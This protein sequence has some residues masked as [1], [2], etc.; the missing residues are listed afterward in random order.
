MDDFG[1]PIAGGI[2]AV[3]R[4]VS[5][6][7]FRPMQ[8][9]E[10]VQAKPDPIT[11][12][13]LSQNSLALTSISQQLQTVSSQ[14]ASLNFSLNGIKE[15]L[16]VSD[17][18]ERQREAARRNRERILAEQG[19]REGKE[20][21]LERKI[22][23]ALTSPLRRVAA[24]TRGILARLQDFFLIIAGGWLTATGIDLL[25]AMAEGNVDKINEYKNKFLKGLLVIGGAFTALQVGIGVTI[26]L[27]SRFVGTVARV[28]FGGI[29][30]GAFRGVRR[31]LSSV[32]GQ[33]IGGGIGGFFG[34]AAGG[35]VSGAVS[36]AAAGAG[37][38][39]G[40]KKIE[41]FVFK[42]REPRVIEK[43]F[44]DGTKTIK[45][46]D[47]KLIENVKPKGFFG[48]SVDKIKGVFGSNKVVQSG[49]KTFE[50]VAKTGLGK[51]ISAFL[52]SSTAKLLGKIVSRGGPLLGFI[53][54]IAGGEKIDNAIAGA[55][56]FAAGAAIGQAIIPIPIVGAL[57]GGIVGE[58]GLK[59]LYKG[60]KFLF[61]RLFGFN[62]KEEIRELQTEDLVSSDNDEGIEESITPVAKN[63]SEVAT[64]ISEVNEGKPTVVNIPML[65]SNQ[66]P[67]IAMSGDESSKSNPL[68][69]INFDNNNP[70]TLFA[71][72][73]YGV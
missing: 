43:K 73:T 30:K 39:V 68:P 2:R 14:V 24:K 70:H 44:P 31:L 7:V 67:Q 26:N 64:N 29:L 9:Q 50:K 71:T 45:G 5:S 32:L 63:N 8:R 18:L 33:I 41:D 52:K 3:R 51:G 48:K 42:G 25:Q 15:N 69:S 20:G 27:L 23:T 54:D 11:T 58:M 38:V 40:G 16:A 56:G 72:A 34:G 49:R 57:I 35:G 4:S 6:S 47:P 21:T 37:T 65:Q 55:A 17:N 62:K 10:P 61:G 22:Q 60:I 59:R 36:G 66:S 13:L 46:A 1:S 19:L 28:A 53:F 12:N